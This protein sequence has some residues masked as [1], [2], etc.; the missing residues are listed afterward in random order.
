MLVIVYYFNTYNVGYCVLFQY[1]KCWLLYIKYIH[2]ILVILLFLL[3]LC[4]F[5][6]IIA[7]IIY[8]S[9]CNFGVFVFIIVVVVIIEN[10]VHVNNDVGL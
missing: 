8:F 4:Y 9:Y 6:I 7:A 3:L 5:S 1:I 10:N 2:T